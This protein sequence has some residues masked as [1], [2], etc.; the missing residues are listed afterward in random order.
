MSIYI[1]IFTMAVTTY[2][3]RMLPLTLFRKPIKSRFIRSFLHYVPYACLTAMIFPAI[4]SST[5]NMVSG[6][7]ALIL[8][9]VLSLR[10]KSLLI[11]SLGSSAAVLITE[12]LLTVIFLTKNTKIVQILRNLKD[13]RFLM[14]SS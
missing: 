3:I 5:E 12:F 2:L 9:V 7:A 14:F 8:A 11:V 13:F 6:A 1:Y 10:G 4:L